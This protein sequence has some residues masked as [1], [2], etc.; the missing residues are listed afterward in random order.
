MKRKIKKLTPKTAQTR[1]RLGLKKGNIVFTYLP[2]VW[3]VEVDGRILIQYLIKNKLVA[4][5]LMCQLSSAINIG[6]EPEGFTS[7][8][9]LAD[10]SGSRS[11]LQRCLRGPSE[12]ELLSL[13]A[14]PK[15]AK[16]KYVRSRAKG[17]KKV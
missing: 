16:P 6:D 3:P 2:M 15:V 5:E 7:C 13:V 14:D 1:L 4:A 9:T 11:N 8:W 17:R 10:P 12:L